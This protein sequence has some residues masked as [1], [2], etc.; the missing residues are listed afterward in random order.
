MAAFFNGRRQFLILLFI[1]LF[2]FA[3]ATY[4]MS[5]HAAHIQRVSTWCTASDEAWPA[6]HIA[7]A[8]HQLAPP[9]VSTACRSDSP[10]RAPLSRCVALRARSNY[11]IQ[12][13]VLASFVFVLLMVDFMF[14]TEDTFV[15]DPSYKSWGIKTG[16][17]V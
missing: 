4:S 11:Y 3:C 14:L 16:Q 6:L 5:A 2:I 10:L 13:I 17:Q 1:L 7:R 12:W 9:S 15:Y 8:V